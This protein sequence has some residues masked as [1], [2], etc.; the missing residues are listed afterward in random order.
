MVV[1]DAVRATD[2]FYPYGDTGFPKALRL[3]EMKSD[4]SKPRF[5]QI[6]DE[7]VALH[8]RKQADYG[9]VGDPFANVRGSADFGV[10]GWVGS[11]VRANDKMR[12]LQAAARG[13][14]LVNESV[15]D[16]MNDLANY[17][18]IARVLYEQENGL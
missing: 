8:L 11:L 4:E 6:T 16:S 5:V 13:Q 9:R 17:A 2:G 14:N 18:I 12:R 15:I 7:L 10:P 1:R 3:V